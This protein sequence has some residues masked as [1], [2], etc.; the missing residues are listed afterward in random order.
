MTV[1][2]NNTQL[3]TPVQMPYF[4]FSTW[5][6]IAKIHMHADVRNFPLM[7]GKKSGKIDKR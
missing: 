7:Q 5:D 2:N 1:C 4:F 3:H 6:R